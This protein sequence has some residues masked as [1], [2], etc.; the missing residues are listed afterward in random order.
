MLRH[1][2]VN[3]IDCS[4]AENKAMISAWI[5][6]HVAWFRSCSRIKCCHLVV[7]GPKL[8]RAQE[9]HVASLASHFVV[10]CHMKKTEKRSY[11]GCD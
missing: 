2:M 11:K 10:L 6:R 9:L 8:S 1:V 5:R 3:Y 4:G 7:G